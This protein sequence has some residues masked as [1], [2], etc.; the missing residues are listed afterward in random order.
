M[1]DYIRFN[2]ALMTSQHS[3]EKKNYKPDSNRIKDKNSAT[4]QFGGVF[5]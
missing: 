4:E 3:K 2:Y 1:G 5:V